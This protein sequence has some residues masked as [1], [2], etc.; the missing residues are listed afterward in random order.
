LIRQFI[1]IATFKA[2]P[3]DLAANSETLFISV[4][5]SLLTYVVASSADASLLNAMQRA[6]LDLVI[7]ALFLFVGLRLQGRR[8]R[9]NQAFSALAGAGA[10]L[11]TIAIPLMYSFSTATSNIAAFL[12][13]LLLVWS[14]AIYAHVFKYTFTVQSLISKVLAVAYILAAI[15]ITELVFPAP[16]A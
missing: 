9:F 4:A 1:D 3:Q 5:L 6:L 8:N 2:K 11:N 16:I 7:M 13:L 12:L 14:V 10:I 15:S